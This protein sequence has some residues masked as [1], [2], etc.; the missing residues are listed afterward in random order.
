MKVQPWANSSS[1]LRRTT[2]TTGCS[3]RIRIEPVGVLLPVPAKKGKLLR[4]F[5]INLTTVDEHPPADQKLGVNTMRID[6]TNTYSTS[7]AGGSSSSI[8]QTPTAKPLSRDGEVA[9]T[10]STNGFAPTGDLARLLSAVKE[11]P[12]V[13]AD[14]VQDV[15][16]RVAS[17]EVLTQAAATDTAAALLETEDV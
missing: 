1:F 11:L 7:P 8:G 3:D 6:P 10:G 17:G 12:D 9:S 13:R 4:R 14:L 2:K 16:S 15:A 5:S